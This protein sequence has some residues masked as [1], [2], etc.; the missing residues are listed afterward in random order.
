MIKLPDYSTKSTENECLMSI[1]FL[2]ITNQSKIG[3]TSLSAHHFKGVNVCVLPST[4]VLTCV[5]WLVCPDYLCAYYLCIA[6]TFAHFY[7]KEIGVVHILRNNGGG[8]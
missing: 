6:F 4:C 1:N 3:V 5:S 7:M 8:V 2:L